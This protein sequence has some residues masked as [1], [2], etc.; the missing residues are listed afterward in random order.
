[1][2]R[3]LYAVAFSI[4]SLPAHARFEVSPLV[5]DRAE[6]DEFEPYFQDLV[7]ILNSLI[8]GRT[9][10]IS[11]EE[12]IRPA[13][14]PDTNF[15]YRESMLRFDSEKFFSAL[16]YEKSLGR[17]LSEQEI[18]N[19]IES[20]DIDN[21]NSAVLADPDAAKWIE[22]HTQNAKNSLGPL[23]IPPGFES[24]APVGRSEAWEC[25]DKTKQNEVGTESL[26][27][28]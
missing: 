16:E 25:G 15:R 9:T 5:V 14:K 19:F 28:N 17:A 12:Y 8:V 6:V 26:D 3:I 22:N 10:V 11:F 24:S 4:L 2:K 27:T 13:Q 20:S 18:K 23:P 7:P 1:M 21:W